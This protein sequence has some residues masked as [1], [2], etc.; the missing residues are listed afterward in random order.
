MRNS[1]W[2]LKVLVFVALVISV[3]LG[4]VAAMFTPEPYKGLV[5]FG[6]FA[7]LL[8]LFTFIFTK[9]MGRD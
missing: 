3:I 5:G 4:V 7:V 1:N 9:F 6:L 8:I 2:K